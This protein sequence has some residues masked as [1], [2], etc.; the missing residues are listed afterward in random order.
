MDASVTIGTDLVFCGG[1]NGD[2][3]EEFW[4][5]PFDLFICSGIETRVNRRRA[6]GGGAVFGL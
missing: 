3:S 4:D 1:A 6:G 5:R 2:F